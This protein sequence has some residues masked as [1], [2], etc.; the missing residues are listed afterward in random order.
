MRILMVE[1]GPSFSVADVHRGWRRALEKLGHQVINYNLGDR[2]TFYSTAHIEGEGEWVRA[3]STEDAMKLAMLGVEAAALRYW[4]EVVIVTSGFYMP[5]TTL[6]LFRSRG[7]KTVILHTESPYEDDRQ[8]LLSAHADLNLINDPT[9]LEKFRRVSATH[10]LPHAYDPDLHY[11]AKA[12]ADLKSD[13]A[14]VGT[15]YPSR[16][17]FLEQVDWSG[18]DVL[19]AGNWQQ[20]DDDSPLL[21]FVIHDLQACWANED[22]VDVYRSTKVGLNLYRTEANLPMLSEGWA[23]GPREVELAATGTFFLRH[24]RPESDETFPMLPAFS[25][26]GELAELARWWASHDDARADA[27]RLARAAVAG[28]TFTERARELLRLLGT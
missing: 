10:Y 21:P 25:E 12:T 11:P 15:A 27:A 23:M 8:I 26:P 18:L 14:F 28:W 7:M 19:L 16:I 24:P 9:N 17:E 2:L 22:T 1:P 5:P 20:L 3:V 13:V 6:D 4:P